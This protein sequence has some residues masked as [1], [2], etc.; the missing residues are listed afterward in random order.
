MIF[1][2]F[3]KLCRERDCRTILELGS[4]DCK[5]A[6]A[7]SRALPAATVHAFECNPA[8][9][10]ICRANLAASEHENRITL[11]SVAVWDATCKIPFYP[12]NPAKTVTS[13]PD[14]NPGASSCF[15]AN[16]AYDHIEKYVQDEIEVQAMRLDEWAR[17]AGIEQV[18]AIFADL[19]GA[20]L[21]AFLGLGLLIDGVKVI[22]TEA[23]WRPKYHGQCVF[24]E[25]NSWLVD[26]G[27]HRVAGG[28]ADWDSDFI[29][30]R[31]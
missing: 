26:R 4:R 3:L 13:W 2:Q 29:F 1:D 15:R 24:S 14:G 28:P 19:Q 22:C 23:G 11:H 18:D 5:E 16:G 20:E 12:I 17:Q 25:L 27:F 7:I 30:I 21:Q 9:L 6:V 8:M 31:P 10:G